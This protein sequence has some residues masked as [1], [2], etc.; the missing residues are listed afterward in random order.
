MSNDQTIEEQIQAKDLTAPRITVDHIAKLMDR[1]EYT[2]GT[3][4]TSTFCHAFLDQRFF[5]GTGHSA[6]VSPENYDEQIGRDIALRNAQQE[7]AKQLWA[8]EGYRLFTQL[9]EEPPIV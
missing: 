2:F 4:G 7:A 1:V 9:N 5:L 3:V 6:C 8:L